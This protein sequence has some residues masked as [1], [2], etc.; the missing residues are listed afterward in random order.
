MGAGERR[1]SRTASL[2]LCPVARFRKRLPLMCRREMGRPGG[3]Y[4]RI[5]IQ[6]H[7][8]TG[9]HFPVG[10]GCFGTTAQ[11]H[12]SFCKATVF[13]GRWSTVPGSSIREAM[14]ERP[15][16]GPVP[17]WSLG[18]KGVKPAACAA[19]GG[20]YLTA[21]APCCMRPAADPP[22][23]AGADYRSPRTQPDPM[24]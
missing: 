24:D 3:V 22:R 9:R 4:G 15:A 18:G 8:A 21:P 16:R 5:G 14:Y 13:S 20:I 2:H 6:V 23:P 12:V 17:H 7:A 11:K 1:R 19:P 10:C